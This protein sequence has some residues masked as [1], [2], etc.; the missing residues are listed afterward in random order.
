MNACWSLSGIVLNHSMTL[1][2]LLQRFALV[3]WIHPLHKI[4]NRHTPK[5]SCSCMPNMKPIITSHNKSILSNVT[6]APT[7]QSRDGCN[8]RKKMDVPLKVNASKEMWSTKQ[9]WQVKLQQN[10]TWDFQQTS[11]NATETTTHAFDTQAK[12]TKLNCQNTYGL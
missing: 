6:P 5:F 1:P 12:E 10:H 9:R 7:Q 3:V 11:K 2:V 8:C 4:F